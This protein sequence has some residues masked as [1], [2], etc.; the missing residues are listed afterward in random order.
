MKDYDGSLEGKS[1][2]E[3]HQ[4]NGVSEDPRN[5]GWSHRSNLARNQHAKERERAISQVVEERRE[6]KAHTRLNESNRHERDQE[7]RPES[8][9]S[10]ET[11]PEDYEFG[12]PLTDKEKAAKKFGQHWPESK[13]RQFLT[14]DTDLTAEQLELLQ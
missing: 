3:H 10:G 2:R 12:R 9:N 14:N 1:E 11:N 5:E 4:P 8:D 6:G 7:E 13:Q